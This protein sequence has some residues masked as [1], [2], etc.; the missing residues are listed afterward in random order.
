MATDITLNAIAIE[1]AMERLRQE[2]ETFD[3]MKGHEER[4]FA[5]RLRMG[6]AA[7][8]MLPAIGAVSALILL[9][10][11]AY[12]PFTVNLATGVLFTDVIGLLTAVWKVVLNASSIARL[13]P[14]TSTKQL[15][16]LAKASPPRGKLEENRS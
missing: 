11:E 2:R 13:S 4:W 15:D 14:V 12:T 16:S 8:I 9:R 6:Y 1:T 5:L 3:Q 7:A 10:P